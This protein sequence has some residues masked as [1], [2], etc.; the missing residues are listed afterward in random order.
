MQWTAAL[1]REPHWHACL[2]ERNI[3]NA[4]AHSPTAHDARPSRRGACTRNHD[5]L[6][7]I[8][9]GPGAERDKSLRRLLHEYLRQPTRVVLSSRERATHLLPSVLRHHLPRSPKPT[10]S[11][12]MPRWICTTN[13]STAVTL[14]SYRRLPC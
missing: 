6:D 3:S 7:D 12:A 10:V 11:W 5:G 14:L 9:P 1:P 13:T 8:G 2:A 4:T